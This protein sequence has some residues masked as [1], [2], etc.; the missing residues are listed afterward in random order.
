MKLVDVKEG[1]SEVFFEHFD[2]GTDIEMPLGIKASEFTDEYKDH[3]REI[4]HRRPDL[5]HKMIHGN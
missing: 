4:K 5:Y 2:D 1:K 3:L